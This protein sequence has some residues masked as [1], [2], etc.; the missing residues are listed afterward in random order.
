MTPTRRTLGPDGVW[1]E[2]PFLVVAPHQVAEFQKAMGTAADAIANVPLPPMPFDRAARNAASPKETAMGLNPTSFEY[3]R[4]TDMQMAQMS[5][6]RNATADFSLILEQNVPDGPDKTYLIRKL[7]EVGMWAN[8][9]ITRLPDGT[10]R[11][12]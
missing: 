2:K 6:V 11:T 3:L 12:D 8:V 7:R 5:I 10:P 4:P 9:A 1:R